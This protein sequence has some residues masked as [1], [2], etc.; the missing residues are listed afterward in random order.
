M[1]SQ[2]I[3]GLLGVLDATDFEGLAGGASALTISDPPVL[4]EI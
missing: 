1:L 3:G 2:G 4:A